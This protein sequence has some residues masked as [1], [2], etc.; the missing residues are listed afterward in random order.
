[1]P[2][3]GLTEQ[4]RLP[5]LGKIRLGIKKVSE[6]TNKEYPT[7][8]EYFVLPEELKG[9]FPDK[10]RELPIMIPV[11]DDEIWC[12]QY[13]KRYSSYRGLTCK[14]DGETCWRMI[15]TA[16]GDVA[17]RDT[18]EVVWKK[19]FTCEGKKCVD[20]IAG[21]CKECMNLQ[22]LMP[23]IPGLGIW[24][25]DT[26]SI[27]SI[28]NI[29]SAALLIRSIYHRISFIPLLLTLSPAETVDK[30]GKKKT[31]QVLNLRTR[32]TMRQLMT[33]AN[34]PVT[35]LLLPAPAEDEAPLDDNYTEADD[36][37]LQSEVS[38][39][40]EPA[41]P[42]EVIQPGKAEKTAKPKKEPAPKITKADLDNTPPLT[43]ADFDSPGVSTADK[44]EQK[45]SAIEQ[46]KNETPVT[47][48]QLIELETMMKGANL[49]SADLTKIVIQLK[50]KITKWSDLAVWQFE[51]LKHMLLVAAG[52]APA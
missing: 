38:G 37:A 44:V 16:T 52:K 3:K 43:D 1:M 9:H 25:V 6:K 29:N 17:G 35:E 13:F 23:D 39:K 45:E 8:T 7:A 21:E 26:S 48:D 27:N 31:V 32:E 51:E 36:Q 46:H 34:Q 5:R 15:D 18:K 30:D 33:Q 50:W 42:V 40:K 12:N 10:P 22:F 4:R 24:Q 2:I 11:E 49:T 41:K 28:R 19:D 14:G 47:R 20:Y